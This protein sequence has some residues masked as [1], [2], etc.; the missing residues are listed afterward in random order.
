V[1]PQDDDSDEVVTLR[2]RLTALLEIFALIDI[3]FKQ[4]LKSDISV[5][6]LKNSLKTGL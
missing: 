4:F 6:E 1:L 5:D 3:G 2:S